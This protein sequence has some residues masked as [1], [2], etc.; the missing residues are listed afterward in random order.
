VTVLTVLPWKGY[1]SWDEQKQA[2]TAALNDWLLTKYGRAND[3]G[4][5]IDTY[6]L[7]VD[8]DQ[9]LQP[10]Y[11]GSISNNPNPSIA[12]DGYLHPGIKGQQFLAQT[13]QSRLQT[14]GATC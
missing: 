14:Q 9:R 11:R 6:Q 4:I 1:P 12:N 2:K 3:G 10:Q 13:V 7:M 5:V 8:K